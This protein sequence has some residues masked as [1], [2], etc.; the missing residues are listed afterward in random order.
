MNLRNSF[1]TLNI[2]NAIFRIL[3]KSITSSSFTIKV[4]ARSTT[5]LKKTSYIRS[6]YF[7]SMPFCDR[8]TSVSN[9]RHYQSCCN[10]NWHK[11][12]WTLFKKKLEGFYRYVVWSMV[13]TFNRGQVFPSDWL[14]SL[15][16]SLANCTLH[17]YRNPSFNF[18]IQSITFFLLCRV[19]HLD[20][21]LHKL[22]VQA[23]H[24]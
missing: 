12:L 15:T 4:R 10:K 8:I 7:F 2:L 18:F 19:C 17:T 11:T 20:H 6:N 14:Q 24:T 9:F 22:L 16:S 23:H 5:I 21:D 13:S 3:V 1:I